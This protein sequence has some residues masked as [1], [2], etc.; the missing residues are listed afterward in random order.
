MTNKKIK[1]AYVELVGTNAEEV[2]GSASLVRFLDYSILV[3]YGLRQSGND[4]EDYITNL[5]RN[6]DIKPKKLDAIILTHAHIDHSG[7]IPKLY[8]EGADCPLYIPKGTKGLLTIMWQDCVKIFNADYDR[9]KRTPLYT[10]DNI[11]TALKHIKE[12]DI[13]KTRKIND[14]IK[15]TYINAQHIVKSRQVYME[16]TD[17][18]NKKTLGITG[19]ISDYDS[20]YWLSPLDELPYCDLIIGE[21]TYANKKRL[22]KNRD[23]AT[24]INKLS[25]TIKYA[26]ENRSKVIIPTF[27]LN[28]LQDMMSVIYE[29]YDGD[30]PIDI[31]IDAPLGINISKIWHKL[32]DCDNDLWDKVKSCNKFQYVT[33]FKDSQRFN[34]SC[35]PMIVICGGGFLQ[36]G[37]ATYW[38]KN[39]LSNPK[40]YIVFCGYSTPTSPA[41]KIKSGKATKVKIDDVWIENLAQIVTLNSFSSHCDY[42]HLLNYYSNLKFSKLCLVHGEHGKRTEFIKSLQKELAKQSSTSKVVEH[43]INT[44]IHF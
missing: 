1:S 6:K 25:M 37:R 16:M 38:C 26:L 20:R 41:G 33:E 34:D 10:Q 4:K 5:K 18:V 36:G 43:E 27:S 8:A 22:Y 39:N 35:E 19:D 24:D 40:S 11:D 2:T 23:R 15:F 31:I 17:G 9:Y 3:D 13:H 21:S 29:M 14:N 42:A 28:R 7:L 32:I 30:I 12:C 44:K